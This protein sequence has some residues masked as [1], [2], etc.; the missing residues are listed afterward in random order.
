MTL[1]KM[2]LGLLAGVAIGATAQAAD[3][4]HVLLISID[5]IHALDVAR[6]V[7]ANPSSALAE[8]CSH[9]VT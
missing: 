8:F 6:Y 1:R 7:E 4:D 5:G 2:T 9:G 3:I